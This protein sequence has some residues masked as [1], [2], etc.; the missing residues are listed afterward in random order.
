MRTLFV[1]ILMSIQIFAV[2]GEEKSLNP[3]NFSQ[4]FRESRVFVGEHG[5]Y[6]YS[7]LKEYG[8][9]VEKRYPGTKENFKKYLDYKNFLKFL[10]LVAQDDLA[11]KRKNMKQ[12]R[13]LQWFEGNSFLGSYNDA[14]SFCSILKSDGYED[15]RLPTLIELWS[16]KNRESGKKSVDLIDTTYWSGDKVF[17]QRDKIWGVDIKTGSDKWLNKKAKHHARCVRGESD[18]SLDLVRGENVVIDRKNSLMWQDTLYNREKRSWRGAKEYCENL[19]FGSFSDWRVPTIRE[20]YSIIEHNQKR[21]ASKVSSQFYTLQKSWYWSS[22]Q[23]VDE[24]RKSWNI[25]FS[26]GNDTWDFK[27][28]RINVVCVRETGKI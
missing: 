4:K 16:V 23:F 7:E 5:Q 11:E 2:A 12:S 27:S 9:F 17:Q 14:K 10:D 8:Q 18:Y 20:L 13:D 1:S 28:K 3:Q 26:T 25:N 15:W 21:G 6:P 22:T 24:K 19:I